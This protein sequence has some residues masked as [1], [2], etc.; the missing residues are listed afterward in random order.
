MFFQSCTQF[1]VVGLLEPGQAEW[2]VHHR[3]RIG[4]AHPNKTSVI[5]DLDQIG[6]A[7]NARDVRDLGAGRHADLDEACWA[8]RADLH[9]RGAG[10]LLLKRW[11]RSHCRGFSLTPI[12]LK[13]A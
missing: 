11:R 8:P 1:G 4:R 10:V 3:D 9:D 13:D 2:T 7:R 6:S 5:L 12:M